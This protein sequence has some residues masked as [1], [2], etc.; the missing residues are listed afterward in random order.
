MKRSWWPVALA[1]LVLSG[2]AARDT[3]STTATTTAGPVNAYS[4]TEVWDAS[5]G[6]KAP[7]AAP[8]AVPK[9][10]WRTTFPQGGKTEI[11]EHLIISLDAGAVRRL[12]SETGAQVWQ[13]PAPQGARLSIHKG[14]AVLKGATELVVL[15]GNNAEELLRVPIAGVE[16]VDADE[17]LLLINLGTQTAAVDRAT[18]KEIWRVPGAISVLG[19]RLIGTRTEDG[20]AWWVQVDP[21]TGAENWRVPYN[22]G[23]EATVLSWGFAVTALEKVNVYSLD[24]GAKTWESKVAMRGKFKILPFDENTLLVHDTSAAYLL[25]R[26]KR[27][28][29]LVGTGVT[30]VGVFRVDKSARVLTT[31]GREVYL[32]DAT[33]TDSDCPNATVPSAAA[34]TEAGGARYLRSGQNLFAMRLPDLGAQWG[35]TLPHTRGEVLAIPKGFLLREGNEVVAYQG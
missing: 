6:W 7:P 5:A 35:L 20:G 11:S 16:S 15:N 31:R 21:A 14:L 12:H 18:R 13:V 2:C 8:V 25:D 29:K 17:K 4:A 32:C 24:T 22:S 3:P 19:G 30:V 26:G 33:H 1:A 23:S 34:V 27:S 9:E 10:K 28:P